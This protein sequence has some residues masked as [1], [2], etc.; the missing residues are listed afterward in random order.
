MMIERPLV[1]D[2]SLVL[3][4]FPAALLLGPRQVGKTTL[5]RRYARTLSPSPVYLDLELP[6]DLARLADAEMYL[7]SCAERLVIIDEVQRRP[8]LVAL[9][10]ALVDERRRPGR[11]LLLESANLLALRQVSESL[12]GRAGFIELAP[13]L[14]TEVGPRRPLE[15][16]WLRGGYP[17]AL[18]AATD[19]AWA[20]WCD[21]LIRS[22]L[23][24]DLPQL[25]FRVPAPELKRFWTM[26]AHLHGQPWNAHA[27]ASSFGVSPPTAT[28]YR[29]ILEQMLLVRALPSWHANLK[30]RLVKAPRVYVRDCGLVH[31][32]LG[33]DDHDELLSNPIAGKSWEGFVL[34]QILGAARGRIE[35]SFFRTHA[36]AEIDIVLHKGP[37]V[38]AAVEVKMGLSPAL[39]RGFHEA[40]RDLGNP[41]AWV[42]CH[43]ARRYPAALGV[44]VLGLDEFL[45]S[46]LPR[47][48]AQ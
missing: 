17:P 44:E 48:C 8:D 13:L 43:G 18:L 31:R 36:G 2:L 38:L 25:G 46:V 6:S 9:I 34:E 12:A 21:A 47:L 10:R 16:H 7:R 23:E 15:R 33:I 3:R 11:F 37:K 32:L 5:A 29:G 39:S 35:A 26:L 22:Y 30:K 42:L 14:R 27:L 28:H 40:R 41:R 4:E 45:V 1:A 19:Q 20:R 24:R